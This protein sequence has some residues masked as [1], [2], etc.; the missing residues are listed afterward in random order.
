MEHI[1]S[2]PYYTIHHSKSAHLFL[3]EWSENAEKISKEEFK[4]HVSQFVAKVREYNIKR[5]LVNSL[6][7]H[8]IMDIETQEWHDKE[9]APQ[10]IAQKIEKIAFVLPEKDYFASISL[11]QAFDET[12]AQ[13]LQ[14]RF[15]QTF[16]QA[17]Q[18]IEN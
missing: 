13:Q 5:F 4:K 12:Q 10:Y 2:T 14:T 9:I 18:W 16:D 11:E 17:M 3:V 8:I 1:L 15:F 6:K 7:G